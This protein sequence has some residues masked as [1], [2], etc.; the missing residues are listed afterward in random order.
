[1]TFYRTILLEYLKIES[2]SRIG[3]RVIYDKIFD[4]KKESA[5]A[6]LKLKKLRIP[7]TTTFNIDGDIVHPQFQF[8]LEGE[9]LGVSFGLKTQSKNIDLNVPS[10]ISDIIEST[11]LEQEAMVMDLDYYTMSATKPGQ[12]NI[13]EWVAQVDHVIRRDLKTFIGDIG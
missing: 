11:H 3:F 9:D 12:F 5:E 1:M 4:T 6:F 8:R 13:S 7:D 10:E 2:Y